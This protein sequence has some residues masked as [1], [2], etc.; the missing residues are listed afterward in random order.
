VLERTR[1]LGVRAAL[2]AAPRALLGSVVKR[3]AVLTAAGMVI[4]LAAAAAATRYLESRLFGVGHLDVPVYVL[5]AITLLAAAVPAALLP[6]RRAARTDP[7]V[8]LRAN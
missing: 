2:G 4:G 6:A 8:T 3:G 5:G 7:A 1:E